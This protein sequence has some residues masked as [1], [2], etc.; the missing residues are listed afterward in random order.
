MHQANML[1]TLNLSNVTYELYLNQKKNTR[2]DIDLI[3]PEES[4]H[5]F[6]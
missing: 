4:K 6:T 5:I 3:Y 2:K 1:Y